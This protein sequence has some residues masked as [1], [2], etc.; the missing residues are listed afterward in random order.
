MSTRKQFALTL[1]F[2]LSVAARLLA[3]ASLLA[4]VASGCAPSNIRGVQDAAPESEAAQSP[5]DAPS[6]QREAGSA[7]IGTDS[8][9]TIGQLDNGLSYFIRQNHRPENRAA[10]WLAINAGSVLED[11]D[12]RGF[13]HFLEHM[14]FNGTRDFDKQE[15]VNY[16]ESIGARMGA[17]LN[18]FTS[19]DETVYMLEVPTDDSTIVENAFLILENW[20]EGITLSD[21]EIEKERGVVLE[22]LRQ[23]RG[24]SAR[25]RDQQFPVLFP[26]SKYAER[27]PIGTPENIEHGDPEAIRRFY[28]DWYRPELMAVIVVGD[29]EPA[30]VE[31]RIRSGFS[32][33]ENPVGSPPR[34]LEPVPDHAETL[35]TVVS[36]PEAT[37]TEVAVYKKL[38]KSYM[39]SEQDFRRSVVDALYHG[40]L[41]LRLNEIRQ[42]PDAPFLFAGSGAG[43][44]VR[45]ADVHL[46]RAGVRDGEA[47]RG[48]RAL[49]TEVER[50]KRHGF[51]ATELER[52]RTNVLRFFERSLAEQDK[53]Q[54]RAYAGEALTHFLTGVSMPG[55]AANEAL[56]RKYLPGISVEEVN[57]RA[58]ESVGDGSRVIAVSGPDK[59]GQPLP[60]REALL[61]VFQEVEGLEELA[62][63]EDNTL[64]RPLVETQPRPSI[65]VKERTVDEIGVTEWKLRNGIEVVLKP[66]DF[67]ND[68]IL[69]SGRS[70]GGH[71]LVSDE[72][73]V[74]ASFA[75]TLLAVGGL[76]EF[77][78]IQLGKALTGKIAS[79]SV[80]IGETSE[81]VTGGASSKDLETLFQ[82]I[83]L[84]FT[85]PRLDEAAAL[86]WIEQVGAGLENRDSNPGTVFNDRIG[87]AWNQGHFRRRPRTK[88]LLEEIDLDRALAVYKD[89]F[90]DASDFRFVIVGNF[91]LDQIKPY[92]VN[93]LGGLPTT[94]RDET[95]RDIGVHHPDGLVEVEVNKGL[96][97]KSE[98]D[99]RFHG[100]A[101]WNRQAQ[102]DMASLSAALRIRLREVLREEMGG[103]YGV[104][105]SG[106]VSRVPRQEYTFSVGFG[107]APENADS[108]EA[109]V[110]QE[111]QRIKDE[112]VDED[113]VVKVQEAQRR[114]R[115][116]GLEQ[117]GF[118]ISRL[119]SYYNLGE[120]PRHILNYET[121]VESVSSE[122]IQAAARAYLNPD[123][124]LIGRL[125]PEKAD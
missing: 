13:A 116:T 120:D 51:G 66:T 82:L 88:A 2:Y 78:Q 20:A 22:E 16:L 7:A 58:R 62:P 42:K 121:F 12:Q 41:N 99:I 113:L 98:V 79:A 122:R 17:D 47:L 67:Q 59:E 10:M 65:I 8:T 101:V 106:G 90:A 24:A 71:S 19:F 30:E 74:S 123:T 49:L 119:Q 6:E 80:G 109:A 64:E 53:R 46:R 25:I 104:S 26:D 1:D 45:S 111:I 94:G 3:V 107:C 87:E 105:V 52:T 38:P 91:G 28:R 36:D 96:E 89:R 21:E 114:S 54:S 5:D 73:Y 35:V 34:L 76:G 37:R 93:W 9:F 57:Q 112:G 48:L 39:I 110:F 18:A 11:D 125:F 69:I 44:L 86:A 56:A 60:D 108:L 63:W 103:V 29:I 33:L 15:M 83:Y 43:A 40:M 102:H 85:A 70:S 68:Q 75:P 124:M 23:G 77:D 55:V 27:I 4:L 92:V 118:W 97:A 72:D 61:K 84:R 81:S 95:W 117:N 100:D 32:E 115:E 50:V 14:A 31:E